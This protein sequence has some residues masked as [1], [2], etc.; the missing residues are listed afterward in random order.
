[1]GEEMMQ[2]KEELES[3]GVPA[4]SEHDMVAAN[5]GT[6]RERTSVAAAAIPRGENPE[7]QTR[8]EPSRKK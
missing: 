2:R 3:D 6:F 4:D 1:V 5:S 7:R 8:K